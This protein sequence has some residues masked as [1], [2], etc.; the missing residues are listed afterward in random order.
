MSSDKGSRIEDRRCDPR[1]SI[2]Y[3][4]LSFITCSEEELYGVRMAVGAECVDRAGPVGGR[5]P[6][7]RRAAAGPLRGVGAGAALAQPALPRRR[8]DPVRRAGVAARY[9]GRQLS[10]FDAYGSAF[11]D[12]ADRPAAATGGDSELAAAPAAAPA[13]RAADRS[14][15]HQ[16][17]VRVPG[18]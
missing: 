4:I 14:G 16:P 8:A 1:S 2:L 15:A 3:L 12:H 18:L 13:L 10:A 11:A 9:A 5:V 7:R 17:G 6:G